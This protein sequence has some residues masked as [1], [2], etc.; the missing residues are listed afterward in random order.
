MWLLGILKGVGRA[1]FSDLDPFAH[2]WSLIPDFP[3]QTLSS[4]IL[5]SDEAE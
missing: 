2:L 3:L 1:V 4:S 5:S